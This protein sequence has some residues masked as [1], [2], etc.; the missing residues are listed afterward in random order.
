MSNIIFENDSFAPQ[1]SSKKLVDHENPSENSSQFMSQVDD[2]KISS[3]ANQNRVMIL[4]QQEVPLGQ[5]IKLN[6][7]NQ[8]KNNIITQQRFSKSDYIDNNIKCTDGKNKETIIV[9]GS[10][11]HSN[12]GHIDSMS[13]INRGTW[14]K[15]QGLLPKFPSI[16]QKEKSCKHQV[17][18]NFGPL[19]ERKISFNKGEF[20]N[21]EYIFLVKKQR[22]GEHNTESEISS[23]HDYEENKTEGNK[24]L[25]QQQ[26]IGENSQVVWIDLTCYSWYTE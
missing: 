3:P 26:I 16:K 10:G 23:I 22:K 19:L 6:Q 12:I 17:L 1:S 13:G 4:A 20:R 11:S 21:D 24:F 25:T 7:E 8:S 5:F 9:H 2:F 18:P 15:T 14:S